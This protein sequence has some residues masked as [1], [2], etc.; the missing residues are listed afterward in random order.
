MILRLLKEEATPNRGH[1]VGLRSFDL[2]DPIIYRRRH[3]RNDSLRPRPAIPSSLILR[4]LCL[5]KPHCF[6]KKA[7]IL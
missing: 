7:R 1:D 3:L 5:E 2:N 6:T 4:V